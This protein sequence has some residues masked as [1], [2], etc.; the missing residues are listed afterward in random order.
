MTC[1][2]FL[3]KLSSKWTGA[4]S[5]H[6]G[7][8][9]GLYNH[10]LLSI[11]HFHHMLNQLMARHLPFSRRSKQE[12]MKYLLATIA[13]SIA[14]AANA[15]N[16]G[17]DCKPTED[18]IITGSVIQNAKG[19]D[20]VLKGLIMNTSLTREYKDANIEISL[21]DANNNKT[22]TMTY[23]LKDDIGTTEVENFTI[24]LENGANV[25]TVN[26]EIVCIQYD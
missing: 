24:P 10:F 17:D 11:E 9:R 18:L 25:E 8:V 2:V 14:L 7:K 26:Y 15:G 19:E 13:M 6:E 3:F 21:F 4:C 23:S 12:Q 20:A 16:G 5:S 22:G 1:R